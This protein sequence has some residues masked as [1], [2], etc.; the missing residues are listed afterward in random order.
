MGDF[1]QTGCSGGNGNIPSM[2]L[3][4]SNVGSVRPAQG[5]T[6]TH[7]SCGGRG[8]V[9]ETTL[10]AHAM[11]RSPCRPPPTCPPSP[12]N[13]PALS[14]NQ[15]IRAQ[16]EETEEEGQT[17]SGGAPSLGPLR[18]AAR[19]HS[20]VPTMHCRLLEHLLKL[21]ENKFKKLKKLRN[22]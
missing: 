20:S 22:T 14:G 8:G 11:L 6:G 13:G 10:G 21:D 19:R 2:H 15:P 16:N 4:S 3:A 9:V 7:T 12:S 1:H 18:P 5:L 17:D